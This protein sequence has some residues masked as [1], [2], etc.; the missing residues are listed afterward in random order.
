MAKAYDLFIVYYKDFRFHFVT[1]LNH[2]FLSLTSQCPCLILQVLK[3][4]PS[5]NDLYTVP[6]G[7]G[8][9]LNFKNK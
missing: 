4:A 7:Q 9:A 2:W 3:M 8:S 6:M 1:S 5:I